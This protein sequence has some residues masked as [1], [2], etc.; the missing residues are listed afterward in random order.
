MIGDGDTMSVRS[1]VAERLVGSAERR[2]AIDHPAVTEEVTEKT[3]E[4]FGLR[5]HLELS[6][7][8]KLP[9]R[10]RLAQ[11]FDELATEDLAE[12]S[13]RDKEVVAPG[14]NPLGGIRR[15]AARRSDAV[16]SGLMLR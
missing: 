1:Q 7:E 9:R 15:S 3:A 11:G 13:F 14:A 2:L 10:E 5:Q 8:P 12:N 6:V 4:D 16:K